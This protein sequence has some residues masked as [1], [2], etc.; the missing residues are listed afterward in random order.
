VVWQGSAGDRRPY[1]DQ[2]DF[3]VNHQC[4]TMFRWFH[5]FANKPQLFEWSYLRC[6][7]VPRKS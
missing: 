1:A 3:Y 7:G 6:R 4:E 5:G 2:Q